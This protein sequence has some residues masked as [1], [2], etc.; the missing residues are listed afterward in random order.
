MSEKNLK[1]RVINKHDT[2]ANWSK[3]TNFIPKKGEIIVYD[4]LNKIKIGDGSTVVSNLKFVETDISG[5]YTKPSTGIPKTDLASDVQTSLTNADNAVKKV[6]INGA[7]KAPTNGVVDLG[8]VITEHQNISGKL[9][10]SGD[11][12]T[13]TING[14]TINTHPEGNGTNIGYYTND[15]AY[16]LL[17]GKGTCVARNITQNTDI[18]VKDEWFDASTSYG[19]FT[20]SKTSDVVEILIKHSGMSFTTKGGIGFGTTAWCAKNIKCE[21]GYSATNKGTA[22]NP[23]TDIV[24]ATRYNTTNQETKIITFPCSGPSAA[25]GGISYNTFQYLKFTLTN[26]N[27]TTPRIAQIF[28]INYSSSGMHNAFLSRKGGE[29]YGTINARGLKVNNNPVVTKV[30]NTAPDANGNVS[31]PIPSAVTES[32]V[33]NWGFTKNTGTYSKPSGGI[34]KTDLTSA[35]QTSLGKADTSVQKI[36]INGSEKSPTNGTTDLGNILPTIILTTNTGMFVNSSI[37]NAATGVEIF[38]AIHN[39]GLKVGEKFILNDGSS[40]WA[41]AIIDSLTQSECHFKATV[42]DDY[43]IRYYRFIVS[44]TQSGTNSLSLSRHYPTVDT[45][46]ASTTNPV[47]GKTIY[48]DLAKKQDKITDEN[49]LSYDLLSDTPTQYDTAEL[50]ITFGTDGTLT[51]DQVS[52]LESF[53]NLKFICIPSVKNKSGVILGRFYLSITETIINNTTN[54]IQ[55]IHATLGNTSYHLKGTNSIEL[56]M[57]LRGKKYTWNYSS[58]DKLHTTIDY[59]MNGTLQTAVHNQLVLATKTSG[60]F[61][62]PII[63]I[64]STESNI[65]YLTYVCQGRSSSST[66]KGLLYSCPNHKDLYIDVVTGT[67]E[68]QYNSNEI[69]AYDLSHE[70]DEGTLIPGKTYRI[71]DYCPTWCGD[72]FAMA[73]NQFDILVTA[74]DNS[75]IDENVHFTRN[76]NTPSDYQ[77]L[78]KWEGKVKM[79]GPYE[80]ENVRQTIQVFDSSSNSVT[81][82]A[83]AHR[84]SADPK[85]TSDGKTVYHYYVYGGDAVH[86]PKDGIWSETED[87][88]DGQLFYWDAEGTGAQASVRY[89]RASSDN[90]TV[91]ITYLKDQN[92]NEANYDFKNVI[93]VGKSST[94]GGIGPMGYTFGKANDSY[95]SWYDSSN[96]SN[97]HHNQVVS[98]IS[99][100]YSAIPVIKMTKGSSIG[101]S[102]N[103][104]YNSSDIHIDRSKNNVIKDSMHVDIASSASDCTLVNTIYANILHQINISNF[105]GN[106]NN[107]IDLAESSQ[108]F[109]QQIDKVQTEN[110][111]QYTWHTILHRYSIKNN[112]VSEENLQYDAT[113]N[114]WVALK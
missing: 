20:V 80:S 86:F 23:D 32:T 112:V 11:T 3:A 7:E 96:D 12:L 14:G 59:D 77:D 53:S 76:A 64:C 93:H 72:N 57:N 18:P 69:T 50:D 27:N 103:S 5:K 43:Q 111:G 78:E 97:V 24:W 1:V 34:P 51:D 8:T 90:V 98:D 68:F 88:A 52:Y 70:I 35:V 107:I 60:K 45:Y 44:S 47:S 2:S 100:N 95:M 85:T 75:T 39:L 25:E 101:C 49:K 54:K 110:S 58:V 106:A 13:G 16:L 10:K 17:A 37:F 15:L 6:K 82:A 105:R 29:V 108:Y 65:N 102:F 87:P 36:K 81:Y 62:I 113:N 26:F 114:K 104:V 19:N 109:R 89:A 74:I 61:F 63:E 31:I 66:D 99:E 73:G 67:Y 21:V 56:M 92:F 41:T 71:N 40:S 4:D 38:E 46:G 42:L 48:A 33:S 83:Y 22:S 79:Y 9:S 30:N 84:S 55:T 94:S 28:L 91:V